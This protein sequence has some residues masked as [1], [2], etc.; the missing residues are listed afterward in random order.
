[1]PLKSSFS[2]EKFGLDILPANKTF[3]DFLDLMSLIISPNFPI[4]IL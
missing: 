2:D 3:L 1:M 4:L